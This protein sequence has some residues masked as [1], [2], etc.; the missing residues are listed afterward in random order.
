[1]FAGMT[2]FEH[3]INR[4]PVWINDSAHWINC[5]MTGSGKFTTSLALQ[6]IFHPGSAVFVSPKPEIADFALGRR[7]DPRIFSATK[8]SNIKQALGV[9]PRGTTQT[10]YHIP[11]S[12][13]FLFD[14]SGQSVYTSNKYNP[15]NEVDLRKDNARSLLLAIAAGS[16]P[17]KKNSRTDPWFTNTPRGLLASGCAHKM[18]T[19]PNPANHTLPAVIDM[20][21]GIDPA[22]GTASPK[23]FE[24]V[25]KSMMANNSLDGFIQASASNIFQLGQRAFGNLYSEFETNCRWITDGWMRRHLSGS[26]EFS[27]SWLGDDDHPVTVFIVPPRG[28]R[29]FHDWVDG[30]PQW[31]NQ[32]AAS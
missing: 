13:S 25:L 22:T 31:A 16:F 1:M 23:Y 20:L 21:M 6:A 11:N 8:A 17:D 15:I 4:Q 14:P 2:Q 19:D 32:P 10:Q 9:D 3:G 29:A 12:R 7:V 28:A 18:T 24:S 5:A 27:F 26:S 30:Y